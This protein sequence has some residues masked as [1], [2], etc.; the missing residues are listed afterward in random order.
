MI[1]SIKY[2]LASSRTYLADGDG[3]GTGSTVGLRV[4]GG[5]GTLFLVGLG[6]TVGVGRPGPVGCFE[7]TNIK[8]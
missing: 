3:L 2:K 1:T 4:V 7:I 8:E 6:D 5:P